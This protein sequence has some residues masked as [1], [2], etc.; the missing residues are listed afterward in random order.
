MNT[1]GGICWKLVVKWA[2]IVMHVWPL[3]FGLAT[4]PSGSACYSVHETLL[5]TWLI[6]SFPCGFIAALLIST[7]LSSAHDAGNL[8]SLWLV[9]FI[10]GYLQ[11]FV[12]TPRL[13]RSFKPQTLGISDPG[14]SLVIAE[15][16][17]APAQVPAV[18]DTK[19][20]LA[21]AEVIRPPQQ[22]PQ[23]PAKKLLKSAGS[24]RLIPAFDKLGQT[25]LQRAIRS[26]GSSR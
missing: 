13:L 9:S 22:T 12:F 4:C 21:I 24:P 15:V 1:E 16:T 20:C 11:W 23:K 6:L 3:L 8:I 7:V 14:P 2:W 17:K 19:P 18:T 26:S 10:G 25:P 5:L